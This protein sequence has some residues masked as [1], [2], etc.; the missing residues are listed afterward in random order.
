MAGEGG[1][2]SGKRSQSSRASREDVSPSLGGTEAS[3]T[4]IIDERI[5]NLRE[6]IDEIDQA[7][8]G[9]KTLNEAF[10]RQIDAEA[11]EVKRHLNMLQEPWKM[12]FHPEVEFLRLSFHK[13]LTSRAKERRA[14]ELKHWEN[15]IN[16]VKERRKFLDEYKAL[17][18]TRRRL[19]DA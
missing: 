6:A 3:V 14:E 4:G 9:R 13:S 12:G 17:L 2:R 18:A 1:A 7:L 8:A 10:I 11:E 19:R 15:N 16:L 5:E